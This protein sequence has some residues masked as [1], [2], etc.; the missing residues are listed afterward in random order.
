MQLKKKSNTVNDDTKL[1]VMSEFT[2]IFNVIQNKKKILNNK[3]IQLENF[4]FYD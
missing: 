2:T 3:V 4:M 1:V